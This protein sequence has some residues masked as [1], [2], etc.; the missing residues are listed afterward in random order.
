VFAREV[1]AGLPVG[2]VTTPRSAPLVPFME[3]SP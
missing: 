1:A 3:T 2:G